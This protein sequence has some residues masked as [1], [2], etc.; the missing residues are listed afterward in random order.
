MLVQNA[1]FLGGR[2][3]TEIK[4]EGCRKRRQ[5]GASGEERVDPEA[6]SEVPASDPHLPKILPHCK[7]QVDEAARLGN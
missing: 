6:S 7:V 3:D 5:E 2:E 1:D 4:W